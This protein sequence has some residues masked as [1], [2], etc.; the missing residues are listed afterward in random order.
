MLYGPD[1]WQLPNTAL[2]IY[3]SHLCFHPLNQN[4]DTKDAFMHHSV[5]VSLCAL[6][7]PLQHSIQSS[8][9]RKQTARQPEASM[10]PDQVIFVSKMFLIPKTIKNLP[11]PTPTQI[12]AWYIAKAAIITRQRRTTF[13]VIKPSICMMCHG[14]S[15]QQL[16]IL[17][18]TKYI[19]DSLTKCSVP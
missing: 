1:S 7:Y 15:S 4:H 3:S 17:V 9:A 8:N 11:T 12:N 10:F 2:Y 16:H 14:S 18:A 13:G 19:E 5:P 6:F